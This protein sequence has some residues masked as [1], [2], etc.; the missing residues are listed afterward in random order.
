MPQGHPNFA[1]FRTACACGPAAMEHADSLRQSHRRGD[2]ERCN[3]GPRC[4]WPNLHGFA[5]CRAG[6]GLRIGWV[7]THRLSVPVGIYDRCGDLECC[8][9]GPRCAWPNLHGFAECRAV[10]GVDAGSRC[11]AALRI[12]WVLTHR[13]SVPVCVVDRCGDL[14]CS[15]VGPR[16]AWPNLHGFAECRA[17]IGFHAGAR[18]S[19]RARLRLAWH[20]LRC[21]AALHIGCVLTHRLS[22]PVCVVD[23]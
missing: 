2:L 21:A 1:A 11:A 7:L 20:D 22:M 9:V 19:R 23:R 3:V 4:A 5:E 17:V 16:C 8:D 12:G 15:D 14:E 10:I 6:R 13:L 18:L